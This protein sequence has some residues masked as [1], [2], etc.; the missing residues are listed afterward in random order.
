MPVTLKDIARRVGKS[1]P[2][3][4]RALGGFEDISPETRAEVQRVAREMGYEPSATATNLKKQRTNNITLVMPREG[5]LRFSDPFFS[6]FV[7]GVVDQAARRGFDLSVSTNPGDDECATYL[8]YIRSRRTDGFIVMRVK[9]QD[10]RIDLLRAEGMPFVAFGRT[11]DDADYHWVDEDG[12]YGMQQAVDHLVTLGHTRLA[13][14]AEPLY[15]AKAHQR[16]DGFLAGVAAHGLRLVPEFV[17]EANFR[18][19]SGRQAAK[20]L[21]DLPEPPT[22]IVACND[23]L[24]LGAMSEVQSRGLVVGEDVSITGFDDIMLAEYA[25]PPLTTLHQPG[26]EMGKAVVDMLVK[27]IGKQALS[28]K[29][30]LRR[31]ELVVRQSTGPPHTSR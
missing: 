30:I 7:S 8:R 20:Y 18:Q 16:L 9:R 14:I 29:Q 24:A 19:T 4:S 13:F 17:A 3:V 21:L 28:E 15:L 5:P 6:E 11:D 2:T 10:E 22:A 27:V 31:P 12:A 25:H 26:Q 1:V 23:L